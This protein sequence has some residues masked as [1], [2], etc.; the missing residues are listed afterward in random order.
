MRFRGK[1]NMKTLAFEF[2][3][4]RRSVAVLVE[5]ATRGEAHE[6]GARHTR[7]FAL[8][9]SAL[10]NASVDRDEIELIAVGLGPG[11]YTGIRSSIAIAQGW[12]AARAVK[13]A[14][15]GSVEAMAAQAHAAGRRGRA[16]VFIDAQRGEFYFAAYQLAEDAPHLIEPLRIVTPEEAQT[17]SQDVAPLLWPEIAAQF[18]GGTTC[19]PDATTIGKLALAHGEFVE[20]A[21]LTP[22]YLRPVTF[23]KAPPLRVIPPV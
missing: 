1:S 22:V 10:Q 2:S 13:L 16:Q 3:S 11:S 6:T 14:G 15:V 9:E 4:S 23:V 5:G 8:I 21:A 18:P 17:L 7:A 20:G 19:L 12:Q